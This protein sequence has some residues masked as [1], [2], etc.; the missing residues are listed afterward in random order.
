MDK[1]FLKECLDKGM[2]TRDIE[3]ICDKIAIIKKGNIICTKTLDEINKNEGG[4]E[5]FYLRTI[6]MNN[7]LL[8]E[9]KESE[10]KE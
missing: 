4:L 8:N 10:G 1:E 9:N 3:K 7:P 2:S 5:N 6:N